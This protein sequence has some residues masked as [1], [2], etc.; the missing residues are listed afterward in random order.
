[1]T[2]IIQI[3]KPILKIKSFILLITNLNAQRIVGHRQIAPRVQ[4]TVAKWR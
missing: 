1:M 2:V 4:V 3:Q